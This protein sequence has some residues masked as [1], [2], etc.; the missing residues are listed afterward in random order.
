MASGPVDGLD[1]FY[2]SQVVFDF[3][4]SNNDDVISA[5]DRSSTTPE[6]VDFSVRDTGPDLVLTIGFEDTVTFNN[7]GIINGSDWA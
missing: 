1:Y 7:I 5:S 4:D 2:E 3:F 6:G